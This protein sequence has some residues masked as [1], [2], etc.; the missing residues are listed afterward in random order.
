MQNVHRQTVRYRWSM[1]MKEVL[2]TA[3]SQEETYYF[4]L[5]SRRFMFK[6]TLNRASGL[7]QPLPR[8]LQQHSQNL[9]LWRPRTEPTIMGI[10]NSSNQLRKHSY[11]VKQQTVPVP[12]TTSWIG[13]DEKKYEG[14]IETM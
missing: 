13:P 7:Q 1:T 8:Y 12:A 9:T 4:H 2:H 6:L 3:T 14:L 5:C 11:L 10:G